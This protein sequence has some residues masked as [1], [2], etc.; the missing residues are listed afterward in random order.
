MKIHI[1]QMQNIKANIEFTQDGI[2][3]S[4][5]TMAGGMGAGEFFDYVFEVPIEK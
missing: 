4:A 1:F 3:A 5:V 2:K